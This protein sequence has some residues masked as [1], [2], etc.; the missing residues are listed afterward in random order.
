VEL[1]HQWEV[2]R[3]PPGHRA[4]QRLHHDNGPAERTANGDGVRPLVAI[5]TTI[6]IPTWRLPEVVST[7][8]P[9][10]LCS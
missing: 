10:L 2:E 4:D 7:H 3:F 9:S 8:A 1:L 6:H 5:F